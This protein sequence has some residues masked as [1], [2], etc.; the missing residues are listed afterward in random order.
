MRRP[1]GQRRA[2][3]RGQKFGRLDADLEATDADAEDGEEDD[4]DEA[5]AD[6]P[7]QQQHQQQ[8]PEADKVAETATEVHDSRRDERLPN[9]RPQ[10]TPGGPAESNGSHVGGSAEMVKCNGTPLPLASPIESCCRT[11]M[12]P[13]SASSSASLLATGDARAVSMSPLS[14]LHTTPQTPRLGAK[15]E[16]TLD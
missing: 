15:E 2:K 1:R 11:P 3:G 4:E 7:N 10:M 9:G 6:G 5:D 14:P 8:Q 13:T 12:E 16:D